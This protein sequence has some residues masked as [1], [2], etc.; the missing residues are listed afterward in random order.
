MTGSAGSNENIHNVMLYQ[1]MSGDAQVGNSSFIMT[2]GSLTSNSG[3]MFYVTNTTSSIQL[4]GVSLTPAANT[5][6]LQVSGNDSSRGWGTAGSNGGKCTFTAS[7]QQL[8]GNIRVDNISTLDLTIKDGSTFTGSINADG[9]NASAMK[10]TLDST[11]TWSLTGD[12]Y[13]TEFNGS[14]SNVQ[15]NGHT[16]YVNGVAA[17]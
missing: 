11:S 8:D 15:L 6:L 16:L 12:S 5:Y 9:T 2:G 13:V 14:M 7:N 1:S 4:S 10:I 17:N 3:D